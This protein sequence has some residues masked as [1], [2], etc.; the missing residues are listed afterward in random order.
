THWCL[1]MPMY[2][3]RSTRLLMLMCLLKPKHSLR[4]TLMHWLTLKPKHSLTLKPMHL[5]TLMLRR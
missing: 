3:L 2:L 4:L 1:L 5:L